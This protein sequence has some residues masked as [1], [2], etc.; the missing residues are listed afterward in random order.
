VANAASGNHRLGLARRD[1]A[2]DD[3]GRCK[4]YSATE[5]TDR[6]VGVE[7]DAILVVIRGVHTGYQ[8]I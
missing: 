3:L 4:V 1:D 2:I 8:G 5:M 6:E 7:V